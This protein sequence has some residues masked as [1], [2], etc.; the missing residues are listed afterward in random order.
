M[1]GTDRRS[2]KNG[3]STTSDRPIQLG[4]TN[5]HG[6]H[7]IEPDTTRE[8]TRKLKLLAIQKARPPLSQSLRST[9]LLE[10]GER[11]AGRW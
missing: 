1:L 4:C 11:G 7:G 10:E 8:A 9:R 2:A 5:G 6:L 3:S